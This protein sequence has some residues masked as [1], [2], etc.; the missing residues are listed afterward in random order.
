MIAYALEKAGIDASKCYIV[1]VDDLNYH[2]AWVSHVISSVPKFD[3]IYSNETLTIC[4][5]KEAGFMVNPIPFYKR[6]VLSATEIR[7][8]ILADGKW[9][10]LLPKIVAEFIKENKGA[11]RLKQLSRTDRGC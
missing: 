11:E 8:R 5:F 7:R 10:E 3:V 4:L 9:E 2:G 6:D 1:P